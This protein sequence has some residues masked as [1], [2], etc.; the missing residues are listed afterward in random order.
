MRKLFVFRPDNLNF[1][2]KLI[3]G[4]L[5]VAILP[6]TTAVYVLHRH[7]ANGM[8]EEVG[9]ANK[10]LL[11]Q[12]R[13]NGDMMVNE[14][15]HAAATLLNNPHLSTFMHNEY[16][17]DA[18]TFNDLMIKLDNLR[19]ESRYLSGIYLYFNRFEYMIGSDGSESSFFRKF[20]QMSGAE[21]ALFNQPGRMHQPRFFMQDRDGR[22]DLV[23]IRPVQ[24]SAYQTIGSIAVVIDGHRFGAIFDPLRLSELDTTLILDADGNRLWCEGAECGLTQLPSD[25]AN[26][27][28]AD[29]SIIERNGQKLAVSD[30]HSSIS[31]WQF[32]SI[33]PMERLTGKLSVATHLALLILLAMISVAIAFSIVY[34]RY[35]YRPLRMLLKRILSQSEKG[36]SRGDNEFLLIDEAYQHVLHS[37][38][39]LERFVAS[40]RRLMV[41]KLLHQVLTGQEMDPERILDK[42]NFLDIRLPCRFFTVVMIEGLPSLAQDKISYRNSAIAQLTL[43]DKAEQ[44]LAEHAMTG[45]AFELNMESI[46][47][48]LNTDSSD[49]EDLAAFLRAAA[50][51]YP[52]LPGAS[53]RIGTGETVEG[54]GRLY[55]S[56][57]KARYELACQSGS[58]A[59]SPEYSADPTSLYE[60][61]I[62]H[63]LAAKDKTAAVEAIQGLFDRLGEGSSLSWPQVVNIGLKLLSAVANKL[64]EMNLAAYQ[65]FMQRAAFHQL[66]TL[67]DL[68]ALREWLIRLLGETIDRLNATAEG[69]ETHH[70]IRQ[71]MHIV[72]EHYGSELTLENV[73]DRVG[74]NPAYLSKLFKDESGSNFIEYV[75]KI[76][77]GI[78]KS[79]M[80]DQPGLSLDVIAQRVGYNNTQSFTRFFKKYEGCTPGQFRQQ[81]GHVR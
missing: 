39:D 18:K 54:L 13:M 47:I 27:S 2:Y 25:K 11:E 23:M 70:K 46:A 35:L 67:D 1:F 20:A 28:S 17:N 69:K 65:E 3:I 16:A 6:T 62:G 19:G 57:R 15:I 60:K 41:S 63:A 48:V 44:W 45:V 71:V 33:L 42:L 38:T 36:A 30:S 8:M 14:M 53:L 52:E 73:A 59:V 7:Y 49:P 56:Y 29:Y 58:A 64:E 40:N 32:I 24:S 37:K 10:R 66:S 61:K 78:G 21:Q 12:A 50:P 43:L 74:L 51:P 72:Q 76:R 80:L 77:I 5:L 26:S 68:P 75:N 9:A 81:A 22:R 4:M 34:G 55:E 31:Q 79:L